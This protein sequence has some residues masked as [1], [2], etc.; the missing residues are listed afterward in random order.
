MT[1][2]R[3]RV[4]GLGSFL[5]PRV[6]TNDDLAQIMDTSDEWIVQRTGIKERRWVEGVTS[7]S[8]LAV[9]AS[10]RA[11]DSAGLTP[12]DLDMIF[13]AT[14]SPDHFFPGSG[15]FLQTKLGLAGI[16][17]IDVRQQCTGFIYALSMADQYIRTG[18]A[19]KIL[20]VG[21]EVHSKG[22]DK[23]TNGRDITVLFGDGAGAVVLE[24]M[25][26]NNP[27]LDSHLLSTHLYTDGAHAEDLWVPAVSTAYDEQIV[28]QRML[29]RGDQY[30]KMNGRQVFVHAVK[31]MPEAVEIALEHNGYQIDDVDLFVFH[32]A[33]L[34]INEAVAH[35]LGAP[36]EKVFNTIEKYANTTAATIPIGLDEAVKAGRLQPGMLVALAAFGGG[37]TWGSALLRW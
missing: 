18:S 7:T 14:I 34:R 1:S 15:V 23:S 21:A 26:V 4:I 30:P 10:R 32:Q 33:N 3:S 29:D 8:D 19:R 13:L 9:E 27:Q 5:P 17:A 20:V 31:R 16:P 12:E 36:E 2:L 25:E 22:L 37:F 11:L 35:R 28:D 6:V 24:A